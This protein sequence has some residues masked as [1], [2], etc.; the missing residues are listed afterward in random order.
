M[1]K[2][3]K[4]LD[5]LISGTENEK[6]K[7]AE[8]MLI[9]GEITSIKKKFKKL[10]LCEY[11]IPSKLEVGMKIRHVDKE[12]KK[13]S[14]TGIISEIEYYSMI[15]R[16]EIKTIY[17]YNKTPGNENKFWKINPLN[18]YIFKYK[19][20]SQSKGD[21]LISA[22]YDDFFEDIKKYKE[23]LEDDDM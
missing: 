7:K 11:V 16:E 3:N 13:C 8:K 21:K 1:D 18:C 4:L 20:L 23:N 15:K 6:S 2:T 14:I 9:K 12:L 10:E 5:L 22:L 17:L 19:V